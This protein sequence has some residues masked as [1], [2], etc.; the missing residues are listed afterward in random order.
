MTPPEQESATTGALPASLGA[1]RLR[2]ARVLRVERSWPFLLPALAALCGFAILVLLA[3]PQ[4]LPLWLHL[5]IVL[6]LAGFVA[7]RLWHAARRV[8]PASRSAIDRRIEQ[9]SGLRHRPLQTLLDRP[10]GPR[11]DA[12]QHAV[13]QAHRERTATQLRRLRTGP[14]HLAVWEHRFGRL[15]VALL[16][17]LLLAIILA[18]P[19]APGRLASGFLPG[20]FDP[21]GPAPWMQA[22]IT[23][24]DY[25][26]AAPVFLTDP[27]GETS[28]PFGSV[29]QVSLTGLHGAPRLEIGELDPNHKPSGDEPVFRRLSEGSWNLTRTLDASARISVRGNG[30]AL[31]DW[32]V[33]VA[34]LPAM[35]LAWD[36]A[37]GPSR[38]PWRTRLPWRVAHPYGLN[39]L[40]AEIRLAAPRLAHP[41]SSTRAAAM[42]VLRVPIPIAPGTREG[43]GVA[44]PDLSA[45]P[46]AGEA[47]IARLTATDVSGRTAQG[48]EARFTLPE[49]PFRNPLA[50][51]VLD[52]RKRVALGRESR[53]DAAAD[54][55]ALGDAPG[56]FA[57]DSGMFVNLAS[58]ASLLREDDVAD[59][60][61]VDEA[62]GRLWELAL[63]LEDGLHN[64]RQGAR[65]AAD[66]RAAREAVAAQLERM[67]QLGDKGQSDK[68]QAELE[69]RMQALSAAIARRM[70]ALAEQA[71]RNHTVLPP[72]PDARMLRGGDLA[73]MMQQMRD[74]AAHGRTQDAMQKLAE[75]QSMLDRMRAATPQDLES[76]QQQAAAQQQVREQMQGLQ[77]LVRR[78]QALLDQT[79][80]RRGAHDKETRERAM[81]PGVDPQTAELL[82]RLGIPQNELDA[83]PTAGNETPP[84][85]AGSQAEADAQAEAQ[86]EAEA[87]ARSQQP[88][89]DNPGPGSMPSELAH[90]HA[91]EQAR[92][93]QRRQDAHVQ[94]SLGRALDELSQEF[95]ALSG[96][97][98]KGFDEAERQ[99]GKA[100]EALSA[101]H[102]QPAQDAQQRALAA[103]QKGASQMQQALASS[104]SGASMLMPGMEDGTGG[105]EPG[106]G[107]GQAD[108]DDKAGPRDPL[109]RPVASGPHADDG[110]THVPD[111]A[112]Q[113]RAR[114]IEQELRRRDTDR[115]RPA[116]EL[117]YLDRLLKPF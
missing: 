3:L 61:A 85:P 38:Q 83:A 41:R 66:L 53:E 1:A 69:R 72:M 34:P 77:D 23:P 91:A 37:P 43:R 14:P 87:L 99:M 25:A 42:P 18:G 27:H 56:Q 79:Q 94:R 19:E 78:Q 62:T 44:Q 16:P 108:N 28:V 40:S 13:W 116:D 64:D 49:R 97:Q 57:T 84:D 33:R 63:A 50:R 70:Q 111:K 11:P 39:A 52:T 98:P 17:M 59:G 102:D 68:E 92:D 8:P 95:K 82:R 73:R 60:P 24:P 46:R 58:I 106:D 47:V 54:L 103:L 9:R 55:Q 7:G 89:G 12:I 107:L 30:R 32:T 104:G 96:S 29:L 101:G 105:T 114:D 110:D 117:N 67:R 6:L 65:A 10:A 90:R 51:A 26:R 93:G 76:A 35:L 5:P 36:G 75:M 109:G 80:A 115:T 2:T 45:D 86:A 74:D 88:P 21:P 4:R 48:P 71:R 20:L 31:A 100:R 112:E 113:M 22:W 15:T 81:P